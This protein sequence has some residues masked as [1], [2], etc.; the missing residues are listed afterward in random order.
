MSVHLSVRLEQLGSHWT[1]FYEIWYLRIFRINSREKFRFFKNSA[2]ITV[3]HTNTE[4][5]FRSYLAQFFLK[6]KMFQTNLYGISKHTLCVQLHFIRKSC[7]LWD[8]VEKEIVEGTS[9][10]RQ[11]GACALHAGYILL[12]IH[13]LRLCN[14]EKYYTARQVTDWQYGACVWHGGYPCYKHTLAVC[15]AHC[16]STATMVARTRRNIL[17]YIHCLSLL[18]NKSLYWW[19]YTMDPGISKIAARWNLVVGPVAQLV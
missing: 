2:I 15:N 7:R 4:A 8:N 3:L 6:W 16:F 9:H 1:D 11:C 12:Y 14:V 18:W 19:K 5:H 13:T 10:R 17:I